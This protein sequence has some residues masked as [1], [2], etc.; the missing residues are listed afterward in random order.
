MKKIAYTLGALIFS[1]SSMAGIVGNIATSEGTTYV[2]DTV[3]TTLN[4]TGYNYSGPLSSENVVFS[5]HGITNGANSIIITGQDDSVGVNGDT[6]AKDSNGKEWSLTLYRSDITCENGGEFSFE[7]SSNFPG[8]I[9]NDPSV[10][11]CTGS[12]NT[13][14]ISINFRNE[15]EWPTGS[16]TLKMSAQ[17]WSE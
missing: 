9:T 2:Q 11:K 12:N 17:A 10:Y 14:G 3:N 6:V 15:E 5:L 13:A 7:D 4:I 1:S 8:L 16:Y